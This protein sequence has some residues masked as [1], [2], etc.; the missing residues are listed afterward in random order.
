MIQ[1]AANSQVVLAGQGIVKRYPG[2]LALNQVD[3][4]V[5]AGEVHGLIGENGAGKS[6]LMHILAGA[7]R[8]DEGVILLDGEP[9][10]FANPREASDR[11]IALVHQELNLVPHLSVAENIFLGRELVSRAGL[12]RSRDQNV[13]CRQLLADLDDTIDPGTK[14]HQLRV[15]QQQVVEIAKAINSNA[16][17]IFMDEPTSAISDQEVESLFRLIR[18]LRDSGVSIV[19]VSHKLE[20]LLNISDR[21]TV[22]RD[23]Q[24]VETVETADADRD[25]IV[26]LMVGRQID[27]LY[28]HSPALPDQPERLRVELLSLARRHARRPLV[29]GVSFSVR[30]GE[31]FGVFGLMGAGRTELLESIFGL[32]PRLV[33]GV[34]AIDGVNSLF[35]SPEQAL[36]G[37]LGLVPE[38]R[39]HKGLI[40][41]MSVEQNI[42]LSNLVAMET[43]G[44]LSGRR[45]RDH[46]LSFVERF[47]IR[48]PN[49]SQPVRAL[50]GGNQQKVVLS[51]VLSRKPGVLML[52]EPT[53]GIDVSAK[54]EIYGLIDRL[55]QQGIAI[56]V[57][58]SEL[59]EM[60]GIAD[61]IMVMCE[62]RKTGEF[63]RSA[64]NE[65]TL[66][67]AAV[68]QT[69]VTMA[70]A[71]DEPVE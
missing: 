15:G 6:T 60:L 38:D 14:V 56:V 66:M 36:H 63:E 53:R 24:L 44:L 25:S 37:G 3:F 57:V 58:S 31:V 11:G 4:E 1:S 2:V 13:Q 41:G 26:R 32:H 8:A 52:D 43:A 39:K 12:I 7:N 45:E 51:K 35:T 67:R 27:D 34:I 48:T 70:A 46:A 23:G 16:R 22:L 10:Q 21:I 5:R 71:G 19:Y 65:V 40:P 49:I 55:K 33:T 64:A 50:S 17:V 68:P 62:G 47:S 9:V 59:P 28:I 54:R 61:R 42:S 30:G 18:S 29:D 69:V 20:E